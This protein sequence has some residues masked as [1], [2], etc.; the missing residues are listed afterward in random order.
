VYKQP[1]IFGLPNSFFFVFL[2]IAFVVFVIVFAAQTFVAAITCA[3]VL[4]ASYGVLILMVQRYG[5]SFFDKLV[6]YYT[7]QSFS[8]VRKN[9][10][11]KR[12]LK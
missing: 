10:V 3:L 8:I 11:V 4:G 9:R 6:A 12:M 7:D 5:S 2:G 1:H